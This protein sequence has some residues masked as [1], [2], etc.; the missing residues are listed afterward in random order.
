MR[1]ISKF[2]DY[3][4]SIQSIGYDPELI[5]HRVQSEYIIEPISGAWYSKSNKKFHMPGGLPHFTDSFMELFSFQNFLGR[6]GVPSDA[7]IWM[8]GFCGKYYIVLDSGAPF[9]TY[10][11][12]RLA[13]A[14]NNQ[15]YYDK[16]SAVEHYKKVLKKDKVSYRAFDLVGECSINPFTDAIEP[17]RVLNCPVFSINLLDRYSLFR[18]KKITVN[19]CLAD[20]K[21]Y[22]LFDTYTVYQEIA[23]FL[24][25]VL[26]WPENATVDISDTDM[27]DAKGFDDWSF[28]KRPTKKRK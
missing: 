6:R 11:K 28:K 27:R 10:Y 16:Q 15:F 5:Y 8:I 3:Y 14:F 20:F 4:D 9:S 26:G 21:F 7:T 18:T 25:G 19:P 2:H 23:M 17:F 12:P 1:I 24:S 22:R 13:R